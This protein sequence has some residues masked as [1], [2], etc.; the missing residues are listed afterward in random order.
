MTANA[1]GGAQVAVVVAGRSYAAHNT[2]V[3]FDCHADDH[4]AYAI[5]VNSSNAQ[6]DKR[7]SKG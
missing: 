3:P 1:K 5:L 4:D 2:R 7:G 6:S